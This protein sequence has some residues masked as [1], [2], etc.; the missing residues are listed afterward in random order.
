[1]CFNGYHTEALYCH[2]IED[3]FMPHMDDAGSIT[4][5]A[6][7]RQKGPQLAKPYL[8]ELHCKTSQNVHKSPDTQ[9]SVCLSLSFSIS[10]IPVL[11]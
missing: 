5:E 11:F 7:E 3:G 1:M 6:I 2:S 9:V 10:L 4:Q 8:E